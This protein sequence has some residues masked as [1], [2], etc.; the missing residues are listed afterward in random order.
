MCVILICVTTNSARSF[1]GISREFCSPS[2]LFLLLC[3]CPDSSPRPVLGWVCTFLPVQVLPCLFSWFL[4]SAVVSEGLSPP[5]S[6]SAVLCH[7]FMLSQISPGRLNWWVMVDPSCQRL[8]P[9]ATTGDGNCLLHAASLGKAWLNPQG[10]SPWSPLG[11]GPTHS[12]GNPGCCCPSWLLCKSSHS[13][14]TLWEWDGLKGRGCQQ[15]VGFSNPSPPPSGK[16]P[17]VPEGN[18]G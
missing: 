9:L 2:L 13:D 11:A 10:K 5:V 6:P 15:L 7:G 4:S 8:L 18:V 3:H 1:P 17:W 14:R 16:F 12:G